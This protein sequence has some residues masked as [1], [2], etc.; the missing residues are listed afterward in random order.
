[1]ASEI[2]MEGLADLHRLLQDL[3]AKIEA[4]VMRGALRAGANVIADEAKRN[5]SVKNGDLR[6]SIR[7]SARLKDGSV[8][9][10]ITAGQSKRL[11]GVF[12][13]H[14]VEYG[15]VAHWI[16]VDEKARPERLTRRGKR[17]YSLRTL[18]RMAK[19]GSL[20]IGGNFVGES[21]EHPGARAKPFMRP[22]FDAKS[23]AAVEA[24]A[25]YI[26]NR[27]P[28]ELRKVR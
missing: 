25:E 21:L 8:I 26:R 12:Y 2:R 11:A 10:R 28:R 1:M 17:K 13:A 3:P 18:N 15:T 24:V 27:L 16:S 4:N 23:Q 14:F 20:V 5:V 6:D 22:A 19:R 7:V 9:A